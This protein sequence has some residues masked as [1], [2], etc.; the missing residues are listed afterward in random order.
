MPRWHLRYRR[1]I[2]IIPGFLYWNI[3]AKSMSL[4]TKAGP[5]SHTRSTSGRRTTSVS[6]P[7]RGSM[8]RVTTTGGRHRGRTDVR[9][10]E[11]R[12]RDQEREELRRRVAARRSA[13]RRWRLRGR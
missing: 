9:T 10:E 6:L 5:V 11:E 3:N 7:G 8:R 2:P 13:I 12:E 1:V 4:T